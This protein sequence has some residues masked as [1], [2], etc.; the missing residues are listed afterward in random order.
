VNTVQE[1]AAVQWGDLPRGAA[2][3][4]YNRAGEAVSRLALR[5][6]SQSGERELV[7]PE[8]QVRISSP[9]GFNREAPVI[10]STTF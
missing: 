8:L 7:L 5:A 9:I 10:V 6:P 2:L 4:L 3:T 1:A